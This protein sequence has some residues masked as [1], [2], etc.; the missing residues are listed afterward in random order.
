MD[1]LTPRQQKWF[2]TVK[3]NFEA[4]TGKP[5]GDWVKIA[6]SCPETA[7]RNRELTLQGDIEAQVFDGR[8]VARNLR[9]RDPF[10]NLPARSAPRPRA[11]PKTSAYP[12]MANA[13]TSLTWMQTESTLSMAI[14]LQKLASSQ[15]ASHRMG[16]IRAEMGRSSTS[17]TV[18]RTASTAHVK[19]PVA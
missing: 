9:V 17:P 5:L 1:N 16:Y 10:G 11:C 14:L 13:F 3:A 15:R 2:A 19:G 6:R 12:P 7:Y 18:D 4:K 8:V